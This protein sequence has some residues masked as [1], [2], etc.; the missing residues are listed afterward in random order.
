MLMTPHSRAPYDRARHGSGS[1]SGTGAGHGP[2]LRDRPRAAGDGGSLAE[3]VV[4]I[5]VLA[6]TAAMVITFRITATNIERRERLRSEAVALIEEASRA[7][8]NIDCVQH[9]GTP[10][11]VDVCGP[12]PVTTP[13]SPDLDANG[14]SMFQ[15]G[16][17]VRPAGLTALPAGTETSGHALITIEWADYYQLSDMDACETP[18]GDPP[19]AVRDITAT[20]RDGSGLRTLERTALGPSVPLTRGWTAVPV[21][22]DNK[23]EWYSY[24]LSSSGADTIRV[25]SGGR[26]DSTIDDRCKVLVSRVGKATRT[27]G[28]GTCVLKEG[29]NNPPTGCL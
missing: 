15:H 1:R 22:G 11:L 14:V 10:T 6:M 20:W 8:R 24:T 7:A 13:P 9:A 25:P 17:V 29:W 26:R 28:T 18:G 23:P 16:K 19:R 4:A 5:V 27:A 12:A 3:T 2:G 21:T